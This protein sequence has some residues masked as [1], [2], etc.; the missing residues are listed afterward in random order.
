M[1]LVD[2]SLAMLYL[3]S[4]AILNKLYLP[5]TVSAF[6]SFILASIFEMRFMISI[7]TSQLNER[8][9]NLFTALQGRPLDEQDENNATT[10]NGTNAAANTDPPDE[11][12][13]SGTIYSRFFFFLIIFTFVTLN[14]IMWP[15]KLRQ[16]FEYITLFILNSYWLPQV[17]RNVIKGSHRSFKKWFIFGT[18]FI[19][20][21]P[22]FYVFVVKTN[23]FQHHYDLQYFLIIAAW[24]SLQIFLLFLQEVFGSR[25]FLPKKWLPETYNYHPV[26]SE[27]DLENGFGIE[28]DHNTP[29]NVETDQS[30]A[31][32]IKTLNNGRCTVDCAI[33]MNEVELPIL[34]SNLD[35]ASTFLLRRNYMVTPCR[36]IFHT[37][38]LEAWM[39][40]KLQCPVC[41]NSLPPL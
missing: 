10:E 22:I 34:K 26:L 5:L 6:L 28:H 2:G 15:K 23:V 31:Q 16:G 33:C 29:L 3:V 11:A 4:S 14:S 25:F 17:Y 13:I 32:S 36:H 9:L 35:H 21:L 40:Y 20:T 19:R 7:F 37:Q 41:R 12:Q 30:Q 27:V 38:C 8:S 18:T 1:S 39:K 24:L